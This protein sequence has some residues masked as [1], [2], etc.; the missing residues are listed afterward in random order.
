MFRKT[1]FLASGCIS[2]CALVSTNLMAAVVVDFDTQTVTF[3]EPPLEHTLTLGIQ[4]KPTDLDDIFFPL[5]WPHTS[6]RAGRLGAR[7]FCHGRSGRDAR[8]HG[9]KLSTP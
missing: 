7:H 8:R 1:R 6:W 2:A 4:Q 3:G 9:R 5:Q